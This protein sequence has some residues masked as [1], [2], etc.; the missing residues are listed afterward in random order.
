VGSEK[1]GFS[2]RMLRK[3]KSGSHEGTPVS[4]EP[5]GNTKEE[6]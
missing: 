4:M 3:V 5:T 6:L 1:S 2:L